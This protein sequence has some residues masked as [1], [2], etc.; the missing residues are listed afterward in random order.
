MEAGEIGGHGPDA[1]AQQEQHQVYKQ[2][3]ERVQTQPHNMAVPPAAGT[4]RTISAAPA[5]SA[6]L[7]EH[8]ADTFLSTSKY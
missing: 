6:A 2:G 1:L 4:A 8:G 5:I 3:K 7:Q